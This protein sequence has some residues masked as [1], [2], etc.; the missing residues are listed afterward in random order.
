MSE[1]SKGARSTQRGSHGDAKATKTTK[2]AKTG[3]AETPTAGTSTAETK[4]TGGTRSLP[5]LVPAVHVRHIPVPS[6]AMAHVPVPH[7]H[8]PV[9]DAVRDR[10]PEPTTN[11]LVWY[12]GLAGLAAFGVIGWPVAGVVAA[13]TYVAEHRAKAAMHEELVEAGEREPV[14]SVTRPEA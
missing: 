6:I 12:G 1:K 14:G 3:A 13:G 8:V 7:I 5:V 4:E 10:L 11:R 9:P 2:A